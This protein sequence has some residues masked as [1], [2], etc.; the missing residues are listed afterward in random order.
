MVQM[1]LAASGFRIREKFESTVLSFCGVVAIELTIFNEMVINE[2][3]STAWI[4]ISR[5]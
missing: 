4:Y 3:K 2:I 5:G 1:V